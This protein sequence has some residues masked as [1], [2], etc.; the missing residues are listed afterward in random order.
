MT[1]AHIDKVRGLS[2]GESNTGL[3]LRTHPRWFYD[4]SVPKRRKR[5]CAR[6]IIASAL[7]APVLTGAL[8]G[9]ALAG[10]QIEGHVDNVQLQAANATLKEVLDALPREFKV[11]Y[12]LPPDIQGDV[13]GR[14]SGALNQVLARIL[15]GYNYIVEI[16]EDGMRIV[17]LEGS[18]K[19]AYRPSE[20]AVML[21]SPASAPQVAPEMSIRPLS[22]Y[23]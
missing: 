12:L 16:T 22:S 11:T 21:K 4:C 5:A 3:V 17:V 6:A 9:F 18:T 7:A 15:D 1:T 10:A 14:Y 19:S 8:T 20:T 23:R 13:T 2:N